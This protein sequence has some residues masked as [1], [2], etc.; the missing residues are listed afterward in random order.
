METIKLTTEE[1]QKI[2]DM[3][4]SYATITAQLGQVQIEKMLINQQ[5]SRLN[6]L[7]TQFETE[8]LTA[9]T[10]EEVIAKELESKY[11][12]GEINLETGEFIKS[13]SV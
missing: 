12:Q 6:E 13:Q 4:S 10:S 11:G 1:L 5:L 9:Q 8:Y 7:Q 2:S 3:Q